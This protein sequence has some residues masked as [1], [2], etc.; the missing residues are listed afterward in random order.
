MLKRFQKKKYYWKEIEGIDGFHRAVE[1]LG[2]SWHQL[3]ED[4]QGYHAPN[5]IWGQLAELTELK[6]KDSL[7]VRKW[8]Y[9]AW[10]RNTQNV[11]TSFPGNKQTN[12]SPESNRMS[13]TSDNQLGLLKANVSCNI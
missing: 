9:Q 10:R 6:N 1:K 12:Q 2:V 7:N 11:F 3:N 13:S 4:G 8:L 5:S